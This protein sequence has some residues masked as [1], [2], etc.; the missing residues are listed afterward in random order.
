VRGFAL[1]KLGARETVSAAGFALGGNALLILNAEIRAMVWRELG[2]V[3]FVDAG[4]V[5]AR[6]SHFE[7]SEVRV[8]PGFGLRYRSPIGPIRV[9]LGFK[10]GRREL[11]PG[12]FEGQTAFHI[13][14]GHAF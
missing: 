11:S 8:S 10:A 2:F 4:N 1:D 3:A 12:N 5:F 14:V 7:M 13:S 9:D 6:P